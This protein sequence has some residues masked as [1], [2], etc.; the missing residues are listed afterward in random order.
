M[1]PLLIWALLLIPLSVSAADLPCSVCPAPNTPATA[2]PTFATIS[3][4]EAQHV[5]LT[6]VK[7]PTKH[8]AHRAL[9]IEHGCLVYAFDIR[10]AQQRGIEEILV[11]A[12]TGTILS[13]THE[14][15]KQEAAERAKDR[16]SA[17]QPR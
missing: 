4:A 6:R 13:H 3:Q 14:S 8:V 17:Q 7:A 9:E 11:D 16:A 15:P 1:H 5:A 2:L 10:I 12:G